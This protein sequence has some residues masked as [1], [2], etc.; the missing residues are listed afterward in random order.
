M[1]PDP[2]DKSLLRCTIRK[3]AD[4]FAKLVLYASY[5][6]CGITALA[7]AAYGAMALYSIAVEPIQA[8]LAYALGGIAFAGLLAA[9]VP[10]WYVY[11]GIA[12]VAAIP[13]YSLLWCIARELAEEDWRH[14]NDGDI[15]LYEIIFL[16]LLHAL[17]ACYSAVFVFH[18]IPAATRCIT[19]LWVILLI[20]H[21]CDNMTKIGKTL[22]FLGAYLHYRKRMKEER[23]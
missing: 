23:K 16:F 19:G 21:A 6:V 8:F 11:A 5:A 18:N 20:P 10:W 14:A 17:T 7:L 22:Q 3:S 12:A 1:T 2:A 9:M 15:V 4:V 13:V